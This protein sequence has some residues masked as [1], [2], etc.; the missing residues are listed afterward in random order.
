MLLLPRL[1]LP[2]TLLRRLRL[3]LV[4]GRLAAALTL[5][6]MALAGWLA[7]VCLTLVFVVVIPATTPPAADR[8]PP[9]TMKMTGNKQPAEAAVTIAAAIAAAGGEDRAFRL[10]MLA[11]EWTLIGLW[12]LSFSDS[13]IRMALWWTT[14]YGRG[15][16]AD[17]DMAAMVAWRR[18]RDILMK[19][20]KKE[21]EVEDHCSCD[22]QRLKQQQAEQNFADRV[23]AARHNVPVLTAGLRAFIRSPPLPD[24]P[25][26]F[27]RYEVYEIAGLFCQSVIQLLFIGMIAKCH[28]SLFLDTE[29]KRRLCA[30]PTHPS[31]SSRQAASPWAVGAWSAFWM[32]STAG[33]TR[34][35]YVQESAADELHANERGSARSSNKQFLLDGDESVTVMTSLTREENDDDEEEDEKESMGQQQQHC[36]KRLFRT[37]VLSALQRLRMKLLAL[38]RI[39]GNWLWVSLVIMFASMEQLRV[40]NWWWWCPAVTTAVP[41]AGQLFCDK[42]TLVPSSSSRDGPCLERLLLAALPHL[43]I[44]LYIGTTFARWRKSRS[45][46]D[47]GHVDDDDDSSAPNYHPPNSRRQQPPYRSLVALPFSVRLSLPS[48]LAI[49]RGL[50]FCVVVHAVYERLC[51]LPPKIASNNN[52]A[53]PPLAAEA[54]EI[55]Q[56]GS[57]RWLLKAEKY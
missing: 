7:L 56:K 30:L 8:R 37:K 46:C 35:L 13:V 33:W 6:G 47:Y 9:M 1:P 40:S 26:H 53:S 14:S 44:A 38:L 22:C 19:K 4:Q 25:R 28:L 43:Q 57:C 42:N 11:G 48:S 17:W 24:E 49:H 23:A 16:T 45:D 29:E 18:R 10:S 34:Q 27:V 31:P 51:L 36:E 32:L 20:K 15:V 2:G 12:I 55:K 5:L 54:S 52:S 21:Q 39:N 3:G 50:F 41:A